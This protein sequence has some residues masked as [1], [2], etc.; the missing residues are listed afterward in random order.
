M[1]WWLFCV[2]IAATYCANLMAFLTV[3][4]YQAPFNTISEMSNQDE[5]QFG[6]LGAASVSS[7]FQVYNSFPII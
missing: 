2:I 4:K 7:M 1:G 5:Y 3:D 6:A